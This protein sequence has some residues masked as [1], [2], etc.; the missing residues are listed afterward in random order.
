[1]VLI[2]SHYCVYM[3][4]ETCV[5]LHM[6]HGTHVLDYTSL[7]FSPK[8]IVLELDISTQTRPSKL[9]HILTF[10]IFSCVYRFSLQ[11]L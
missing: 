9:I 5:C 2:G 4:G 10:L 11:L 7:G 6:S 1:M 8:V 3:F